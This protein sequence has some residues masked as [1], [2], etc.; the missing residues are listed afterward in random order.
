MNISPAQPHAVRYYSVINQFERVSYDIL[1][2]QRIHI[3]CAFSLHSRRGD[4][5]LS[6]DELEEIRRRKMQLLLERTQQPKVGE[7]LANGQVNQLFDHN[8]W[9]TI[10]KT[11]IAF[12]D[13]YGE[14]CNPCKALAPIFAE[15][16]KDYAGK[17]F[18]GKIDIDRNRMTVG[19]FGVQSVPMVIVFKDGKPIGTLPGLRSYADYDMAI[20]QLLGNARDES[21]YV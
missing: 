18:F 6:D 11:K 14:W 12:I 13:F 5:V 8:F 10:Q 17:V 16:A 20:T 3:G 9:D 2:Y 4:S 21:S 19:Q 7:P 1:S 15:L